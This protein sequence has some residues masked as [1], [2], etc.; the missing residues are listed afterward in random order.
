MGHIKVDDLVLYIENSDLVHVPIG[1]Y[2]RQVV[3]R[4]AEVNP[5]PRLRFRRMIQV[6]PAILN[7]AFVAKE[8][9][10]KAIGGM[11]RVRSILVHNVDGCP[12]APLICKLIKTLPVPIIMIIGT[13]ARMKNKEMA[14][15]LCS[16]VILPGQDIKSRAAGVQLILEACFKTATFLP[17]SM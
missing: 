9:L 4:G 5:I 8:V 10:H 13:I 15:A 14:E 12:Y 3:I 16:R 1:S 2:A 11:K 6:L 17:A 7:P